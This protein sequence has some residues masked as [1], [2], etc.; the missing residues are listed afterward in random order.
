MLWVMTRGRCW[1]MPEKSKFLHAAVENNYFLWLEHDAHN[2]IITVEN[3]EKGIRLANV[4]KV[5]DVL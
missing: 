3:T 4:F 2:Q 1:T 5:E